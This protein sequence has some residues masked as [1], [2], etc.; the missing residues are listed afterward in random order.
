MGKGKKAIVVGGGLAGLTAGLFLRREGWEVSVIERSERLGGRAKTQEKEGFFLNQG[1][2][3]LYRG[4]AGMRIL[5]EL[6][7]KPEG[8]IPGGGWFSEGSIWHRLPA[9]PLDLIRME[10]LTWKQRWGLVRILTRI[11]VGSP[12][13]ARGQS[14][15]AWLAAEVV[16][17]TVRRIVGA[18]IRLASYGGDLEALD[19]A[20]G[21]GQL[22]SAL[23]YG[24]LY[25]HR[26]WSS[27]VEALAEK[28]KESGIS[29]VSGRQIVSLREGE[30]GEEAWAV[31]DD[32]GEVWKAD[33]VILAIPPKEIASILPEGKAG[34]LGPSWGDL[35]PIYAACLD[36]GL[37][38]LPRPEMGF[39]LDLREPL[40][41]SVASKVA[42]VAPEGGAVC[43]LLWYQPPEESDPGEI[44]GRLEAYLDRL[45]EGW[46]EE[47]VWKRFLPKMTVSFFFPEATKGGLQGRP[48]VSSLGRPGLAIAGDWVGEEGHLADASFASGKAAAYALFRD[49]RLRGSQAES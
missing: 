15:E 22:R 16:D 37:R 14:V 33:G 2:H 43:H 38:R 23:R 12:K 17:P 4:G 3:A 49:L 10:T 44:Q 7:I 30:A 19:G 18:L 26:G 13:R 24:V 39:A 25:L 21:W 11:A 28:A 31:E 1:A 34:V 5:K 9:S 20:L 42:K 35:K 47:V 6:G 40:Y 29:W 48:A 46:R 41:F 32:R 27:L 36:L 45:Q 8:G